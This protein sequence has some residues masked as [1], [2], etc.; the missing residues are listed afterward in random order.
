MQT[1]EEEYFKSQ[2]YGKKEVAIKELYLRFLKWAHAD[3]GKGKSALDVG[4]A[5]GYVVRLLEEFGYRSIGLE[6]S[7]HACQQSGLGNRMVQGN[8][9]NFVLAP[10]SFNL[11]TCFE[12]IEHLQ[13]PKA[14]LGRFHEVLTHDGRLLLTTPTR[15]GSFVSRQDKYHPSVKSWREWV[16]LLDEVG[17]SECRHESYGMTPRILGKYRVIMNPWPGPATHILVEATK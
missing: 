13:N 14:A 1:Y 15:F 7:Q 12:V 17:F 8:A 9:E 10:C 16:T 11:V 5:L 3:Q 2:R 4:A 6:I